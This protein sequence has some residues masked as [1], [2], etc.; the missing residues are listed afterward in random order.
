MA[1]TLKFSESDLLEIIRDHVSIGASS[2]SISE[3]LGYSPTWLHKRCI[4]S[5]A[6]R[7]AYIINDL[8][9]KS[10]VRQTQNRVLFDDNHDKYSLSAAMK[11]VGRWDGLDK[12]DTDESGSEIKE[13]TETTMEEASLQIF[14][15]LGAK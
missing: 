14:V 12:P 7:K 9:Y 15:D 8:R 4:D 2:R 3:S 1:K 5:D 10:T 11:L 13:D 6:L